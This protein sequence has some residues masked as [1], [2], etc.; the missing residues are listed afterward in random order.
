MRVP[1]VPETK[2]LSRCGKLASGRM[3]RMM[4]RLSRYG[5]S[6]LCLLVAV[7]LAAESRD[8]FRFD[9]QIKQGAE[10]LLQV[11]VADAAGVP[12]MRSR[13]SAQVGQPIEVS[14]RQGELSFRVTVNPDGKQTSV[15]VL[16]VREGDRVVQR[17]EQ[18][19]KHETHFGPSEPISLELKDADIHDV[20]DTFSEVTGRTIRIASDVK[21]EVTISLQAVPW[22]DALTQIAE[23]LG[24]VPVVADD[25]TIDLVTRGE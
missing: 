12:F 1:H 8:A 10:L 7:P 14:S 5:L 21:G 18:K 24:L 3:G 6:L 19:V 20:I 23:P 16:E 9:V 13:A 2:A 17:T 15:A 22:H 25:G 4:N 11:D